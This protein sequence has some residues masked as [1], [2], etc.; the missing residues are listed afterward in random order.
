MR[1]DWI[2]NVL[3]DL[4][5]YAQANGLPALAQKV[6]EAM[7]VARIEADGAVGGMDVSEASALGPRHPH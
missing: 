2:F 4:K 3:R 1:H 6:D 7:A 5:T